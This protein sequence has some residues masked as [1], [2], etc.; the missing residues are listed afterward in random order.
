M[1]DL[2]QH[3][4]RAHARVLL[5]CDVDLFLTGAL[6]GLSITPFPAGR[7]IGSSVWRISWQGEVDT[8]CML[9]CTCVGLSCA[10]GH[11][12]RCW[13]RNTYGVRS[14][15]ANR[16]VLLWH[17]G[18]CVC[19]RDESQEGTPA[20]WRCPGVCLLPPCHADHRCSS[21]YVIKC[22]VQQ[23]RFHFQHDQ[24]SALLPR[25]R[26]HA[27]LSMSQCLPPELLQTPSMR[28][29]C[30][31]SPATGRRSCSQRSRQRCG[32]MARCNQQQGLMTVYLVSCQARCKIRC[33][34]F[35]CAWYKRRC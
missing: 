34:S 29:S 31:L 32:P 21:E 27:C 24:K 5:R 28:S 3:A 16:A 4:S 33:W 25:V 35:T 12:R 10:R 13:T 17:A 19:R 23:S 20:E 8:L 14:R 2:Q 15:F 1:C 6:E 30:S 22:A 7:L 9:L 26:A 18:L 11:S